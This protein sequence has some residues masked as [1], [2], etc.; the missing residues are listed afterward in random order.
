MTDFT[1]MHWAIMPHVCR[2]CMGRVLAH[3]SIDGTKTFRCSNCGLERNGETEIVI[4]S[5]GLKLRTGRDMGF[6]CLVN[7][8]KTPECESEIVATQVNPL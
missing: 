5:C 1:D 7:D 2:V 3:K 8:K 4:C 6:R